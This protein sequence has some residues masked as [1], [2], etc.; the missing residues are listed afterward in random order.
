MIAGGLCDQSVLLPSKTSLAFSC[1]SLIAEESALM[2]K[3][4]TLKMRLS[5]FSAAYSL[6]F[7]VAH[8]PTEGCRGCLPSL[9]KEKV[10]KI[11][12]I[13]DAKDPNDDCSPTGTMS[14]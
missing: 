2:N 4:F 6:S 13:S 7:A 14:G 9:T 1:V 3:L 8:A 5:T 10:F 12:I 11:T